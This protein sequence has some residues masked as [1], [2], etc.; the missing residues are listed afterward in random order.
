MD[1]NPIVAG[2]F[3]PG[4]PAALRD[5][6]KRLIRPNAP[7]EDVIGVI[8]PH[9][10]YLYSGG[11]AGATFSRIQFKDTCVILG[12]NHTGRGVPFSIMTEGKWNTPL[13]D[14][15]INSPLG[16]QI[17]E[18]SVHLREDAAAHLFEHSI[19]VQVPFLQ[20]FKSDVQ[21]VPIVLAP[22]E[23]NV[24]QEIGKAIADAI[25][26]AQTE[27]LIVASSDMTHY[28]SQES[29]Q[30]KD[31]AAIKAIL[32][33]DEDGLLRRIDDLRI[34]MCGYGP[35]VTLIAAAKELGAS[36]AELVEYHTSGDVTGDR[37]SV[38]GYA[39]I[40]IKR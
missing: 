16:T 35:V 4:T 8:S 31:S 22:A 24:Y 30:R 10:G 28:E 32:D 19:E 38:V 11:T 21:I 25:K 23:K 6:I 14:V 40:L 37:R 29:A 17:R 15:D 20:Y 5:E 12:P 27:V 36:S 26:V 7:K 39:G 13:G 33:L 2:Q 18:N 1:R 34:S 3:Y 9:A